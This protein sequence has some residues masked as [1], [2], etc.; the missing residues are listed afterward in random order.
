MPAAR[1]LEELFAA[2]TGA[3]G[4]VAEQALAGLLDAAALTAAAEGHAAPVDALVVLVG[5]TDAEQAG[6]ALQGAAGSMTLSGAEHEVCW[7]A[8]G[9]PPQ[10][11]RASSVPL[12]CN[13]FRPAAVGAF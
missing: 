8:S 9:S 10:L 2:A 11:P 5:S 7:G 6:A 13:P 1:A 4:Q 3:T 12:R